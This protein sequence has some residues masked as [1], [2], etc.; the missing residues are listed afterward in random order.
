MDVWMG[1]WM[2]VEDHISEWFRVQDAWWCSSP[3][4]V[5]YTGSIPWESAAGSGAEAV[6]VLPE[7]HRR[8]R[9]QAAPG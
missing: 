3:G 9:H 1:G 7:D 5:S 4:G 8:H 2:E 6:Q